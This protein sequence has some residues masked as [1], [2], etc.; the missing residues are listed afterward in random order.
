[1]E[2]KHFETKKLWNKKTMKQKNYE[3]KKLWNKK[4]LKQ[5]SYET[6]KLWNKGRNHS[7]ASLFVPMENLQVQKPIP[8]VRRQFYFRSPEV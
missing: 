4:T 6:E 3:T 7:F 1:M 2:Q 5:K 8:E